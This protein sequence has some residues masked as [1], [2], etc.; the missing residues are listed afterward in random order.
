M[1]APVAP[2]AIQVPKAGAWPAFGWFTLAFMVAAQGYAIVTSPADR[3]MGDLQK[4]LYVHVPASWIMSITFAL[5][6]VYSLLYLWKGRE[7][8]DLLAASSA[9]VGATFV[10]LTLVQGMIWGKPTWGVWWTW[11]ARL[12]STLVLF[13]VFVGYLALR[14]FIDEP[15]RR[16]QWSAAVGVLGSINVPIVWMSVRWW[17]TLHQMQS[18]PQT[19]DPAYRNGLLVNF[20]AFTLL[21]VYLIRR[22]YE[23]SMTARAAELASQ[24]MALGGH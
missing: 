9:E 3:D 14:A 12:T 16:G 4:I 22:R 5:V 6:F 20:L 10:G 1:T 7:S 11:D 24:A 15:Q 13:L 23:A 8:H 17:R 19:M 2:P 18:T 21:A